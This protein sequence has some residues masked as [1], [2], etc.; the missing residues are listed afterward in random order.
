MSPAKSCVVVVVV[1][2]ALIRTSIILQRSVWTE[3]S[4]CVVHNAT[5][6]AD[7]NCTYNCGSDCWRISKYPCL[8][9]YVSVNNTGRLCRL[10]HNEETQDASSEVSYALPGKYKDLLNRSNVGRSRPMFAW[11]M[12]DQL[13][14]VSLGRN[15]L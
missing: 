7:M 15:G 8:Q 9:V 14:Q 2:F 3:E 13:D 10:S 6:T 5:V 12:L 11:L 1:V 4:V